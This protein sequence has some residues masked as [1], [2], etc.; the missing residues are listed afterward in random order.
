MISKYSVAYVMLLL[1]IDSLDCTSAVTKSGPLIRNR[2]QLQNSDAC[3]GHYC[4]NG[5]TCV[6]SK[7]DN[8]YRCSCTPHWGGAFCNRPA[9]L[10]AF[11]KAGLEPEMFDHLPQKV[12]SVKYDHRTPS[13]N[14]SLHL[15]N[16]LTPTQV[17]NQPLVINWPGMLP[18]KFYTIIMVDPDMPSRDAPIEEKQQVLHWMLVN[19]PGKGIGGRVL[20]SY[21]GSGPPKKTGLHRYTFLVFEEGNT[22]KDYSS[23][24]PM[25]ATNIDR[26]INWSFTTPAKQWTIRDFIAWAKIGQPIAGNFY[27]AEWDAWVDQLWKTFTKR[28]TVQQETQNGN[29]PSGI[30]DFFP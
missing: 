16:Q 15:G 25:D 7:H 29:L 24:M 28:D 19:I 2:R 22:P 13:K 4:S 20:A 30:T 1:V 17:K 26:R 11:S 10:D 18:Y 9:E 27:V 3:D 5:A 6:A 8:F 21:I 12:L 23:V 14:N